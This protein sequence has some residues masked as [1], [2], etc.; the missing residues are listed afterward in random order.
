[1]YLKR[2]LSALLAAV[3]VMSSANITLADDKA[4]MANEQSDDVVSGSAVIIN[5]EHTEPTGDVVETSADGDI[6]LM[7][8][9]IVAY[10]VEGGNIYFDKSRGTITDTD[11]SITS[12]NI[13]ST[14]EDV[15][16]TSIG[17]SAFRN[18]S[19][20]TSIIIPGS[21]TS[22]GEYAFYDCS[23]LTSITI[24]GSVTSIGWYAFDGC[25]ALTSISIPDS[26]TYIERGAFRN[27]S[28]L[29]SISIPDS[30]TYIGSDAFRNCSALTNI[31]IP[32]SVTYIKSD[33][34]WDCIALTSI[35]VSKGNTNYVDVEGVL[36]DKNISTIICYPMGK[37][38]KQYTI[39]DSVTYIESYAFVDCKSLISIT[40]PD[41]VTSIGW[42]AFYG[43]SALTS[44]TIPD[45]VTSIGSYAFHDCS[46]LT[47]ITIPDS[48]T[49]IGDAVFSGCS[50]LTSI[51]IP[52]SV[53]SIEYWAFDGCSALTSIDIPDSVTSIGGYA[54][55]GCSSLTSIIIPNGVTSI[56]D[57]VFS[58]CSAL[59]SISIP[60][61]VTSIG[62]E[63]FS[64]CSSLTSI[65]IPNSVTSIGQEAFSGCSSLTSINIP[66]SV[67]SIKYEAFYGCSSLTSISIPD[68]VT[69]IGDVVFYDCSSLTSINIPDSVTSIGSDAFY[70]CSSLTSID[71]PDSVTSI[72]DGAFEDC[73]SLTSITIPDS[74]TSIE[75]EAF[76][77]CS[78]LA[79]I[80]I[81]DSVTS[82]GAYAFDGCSSLT[83]ITIPEGVTSIGYDAFSGCSSLTSITIPNSVT[84]IEWYAFYGCGSLTSISIP[85]SV[86]SIGKSAF[87]GCNSVTELVTGQEGIDYGWSNHKLLKKVVLLDDVT[88]IRDKV[89]SGCSSLTSINIPD[90]VTSIGHDAFSGCSSL[91]NISIPGSVTLIE[92]STFNDCSSL[93]SISIPGSVTSIGESAFNGCSSL[94]NISIPDSVTSIGSE[95][96]SDCS[97]LTSI[98]IPNDVTSIGYLAFDG[99]NSVTELVTGQKGIDYGWS[100]H[101]LL[102]KVVLLEDVTSIGYEVFSGCISLTSITIPD[103]VTSIGH[104][105]FCDCRSL[106]SITIP[107]GVTSINDSAFYG[108]SSLTSISIPDSVTSIEKSAFNNCEKL[109]IY[110]KP[111]S[112]AETFAKENSIPYS[113]EGYVDYTLNEAD[114][115]ADVGDSI[116]WEHKVYEYDKGYFSINSPIYT[117]Q[118][119]N[120]VKD[121]NMMDQVKLTFSN[122][123]IIETEKSAETG[124]RIDLENAGYDWQST[125]ET[126]L[127]KNGETI[128]TATLPNGDSSSC[129]VRVKCYDIGFNAKDGK[130]VMKSSA[131]YSIESHDKT[132]EITASLYPHSD[133]HSDI[134]WTSSNPDVVEVS[135]KNSIDGIRSDLLIGYLNCKKAGTSTI[136]VSNSKGA[137][138]SCLVT[139][140]ED[141]VPIIDN[142]YGVNNTAEDSSDASS[143]EV[144]EQLKTAVEEYDTAL[145][146]YEQN[147]AKSLSNVKVPNATDIDLY[148]S[149]KSKIALMTS[150]VPKNI[151]DVCY[152]AIYYTIRDMSYSK[153]A[154]NKI[155][156]SKDT[157]S[158]STS[159]IKQIANAYMNEPAKTY[160][161]DKYTATVT[162]NGFNGASFGT[163]NI[164]PKKGGAS[165]PIVFTTS[166]QEM[167]KIMGDYLNQLSALEKNALDEA[168]ISTIDFFTESVGLDKYIKSK[169]TKV[170][171]KC[172][173]QLNNLGLGEIVT[174]VNDC[175]SSAKEVKKILTVDDWNY[176]SV[177]NE[178]T[179][180]SKLDP[181][182]VKKVSTTAVDKA[183]NNLQKCRN[184]LISAATSYL[185]NTPEPQNL[186]QKLFSFK[187]P[188]DIIVY[189][190]TGNEIG[191][192]YGDEVTCTSDDILIKKTGDTRNVYISNDI[193]VSFKIIATDYG[194]LDVTVEDYDNGITIGRQNYYNIPL[195]INDE[196]TTSTASK[197]IEN[198]IIYTPDGERIADEYIPADQNACI[199][200][201]VDTEGSGNVRNTGEYVKGDE[202][203]LT[204]VPDDNYKF[205]GWY[206]N[207][208]L[209]STDI[210]YSFNATENL[211]LVAKFIEDA[212]EITEPPIEEPDILYG[213][214]DINGVLT[215][216]D[217][218]MVLQK[219]LDS[220]FKMSV[221][222]TKED[223]M[224]IADVDRNDILTAADASMILQKVLDSSFQMTCESQ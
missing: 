5:D 152:K 8:N 56:R 202:V 137:S 50:A 1:M 23:S 37:L 68:S 100:N 52:D 130:I 136:T 55:R 150:Y 97:S 178:I 169:F 93:T 179:A 72:G 107:D 208:E 117:A 61:S 146:L 222:D 205:V 22:I 57:N 124:Y 164:K 98:N 2:Q 215:A 58:G 133:D 162:I 44:I 210:I 62:Q 165:I 47:S 134:V 63:A 33:A 85:N 192:V 157:I 175:K 13:P 89:F 75:P 153:T 92:E 155:D 86:T 142:N 71:I 181:G 214:A 114:I 218:S 73:S 141:N 186:W 149:F 176:E 81:P 110:C 216:A 144:K 201:S 138:A 14:I 129:L 189:D 70:G 104:D 91:K 41:G 64:G 203:M 11:R 187:C 38:D 115:P 31:S 83:S 207:E 87:S 139:V 135:V 101:K 193:E 30:V 213:D 74:I 10:P 12:A 183:Y 15:S 96:F 126:T 170:I 19:S 163:V 112:Y 219:V 223:Y 59:T 154:L 143:A 26:V 45:S 76:N 82:I 199:N 108:C 159:I 191:S 171:D 204:A 48:V 88:S 145:Y 94:K 127:L 131:K 27:C 46:A 28:A 161:I 167:A 24:P 221:E 60:N 184:K 34:F 105:A 182:N 25:S 78:S 36:F 125:H 200:I 43:C 185:T 168:L 66:D 212:E 106:T 158:V 6:K 206:N 173:P 151:E 51:S 95:A 42:E 147:L 116:R 121:E 211:K 132:S 188:V 177:Y 160:D 32:D 54:F 190:K 49:S 113:A 67:T 166:Q 103:G 29:T 90:G 7:V 224:Y 119:R 18:R 102:K 172:T 3:M 194:L 198:M 20:L 118:I 53:T 174:F 77:G 80:S 99:C 217:A 148:N 180:I 220:S 120:L 16:V 209:L 40:I 79:S 39:P 128:V 69:S 196:F 109:T 156:M 21:V 35:N 197:Q 4:A 195:D 140:V 65:N 123:G 111:D 17:G 9:S 122:E 84:S